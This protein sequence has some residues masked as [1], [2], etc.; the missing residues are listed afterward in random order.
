[1]PGLGFPLS[2]EFNATKGEE[3]LWVIGNSGWYA[4]TLP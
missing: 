3:R 4:R 1:V 2:S